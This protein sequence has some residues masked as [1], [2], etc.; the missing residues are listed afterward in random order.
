MRKLMTA[1]LAVAILGG[2]TIGMVGCT[3]ESSVTKET[4]IKGPGGTTKITEKAAVDKSGQNPP[5]IPGDTKA[6]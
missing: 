3:E 6:P 4:D 2:L 5:A 1:M